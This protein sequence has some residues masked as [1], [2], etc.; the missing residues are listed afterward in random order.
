MK[1]SKKISDRGIKK[2]K[3]LKIRQELIDA[4][5]L[6]KLSP[7]DKAWYNKFII[8][9]V[10]A[11]FRHQKPLHNTKKLRKACEDANNHR[12]N[13]SYSITKS[14]NML[15]TVDN[16]TSPLLDLNRSTN[17]HETEEVLNRIIDEKDRQVR[18]EYSEE[19]WNGYML[20][21]ERKRST[22]K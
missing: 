20:E 5:Y 4:D 1:K 11:D 12:N 21:L 17:F 9:S 8:E 7:E 10:S 22:T 2:N 15:K 14:N 16:K 13:D 3:N 18:L 6:D 19:E